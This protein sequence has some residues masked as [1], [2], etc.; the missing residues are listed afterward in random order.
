M[1]VPVDAVLVG[2]GQRGREAFGAFALR[3]PDLLRFVA[4]A[5]PNAERR[6][7]FAR[8][9]GIPADRCFASWTELADRGPLA[10][11]AF[12]TTQ[13]RDHY[14]SALALLA[15]G[16]HLFLEK[17]MATSP[18]ECLAI[19]EAALRHQRMIQIC[20]P[21]RFSPFYQR[22]QELLRSGILGR[23]LS[24]SMAENIG[25]WHYAH[26][27]VR[28]NWSRQ[29]TSGPLML[30]KCC[31]DMDIATWL[32]GAPATSV[33]SHGSRQF[34]R[35]E[36]E[37]DGAA[38]RCLAGCQAAPT[39]AYNASAA[40]LTEQP[41]EDWPYSVV[42]LD[43]HPEV[44]LKALL[45]GPYGRC[46]FRCDN[47][48]VDQQA[49]VATFPNGQ[50]LDFTVR[51]TSY[52]LHR[53]IRIQGTRA[54]LNGHFEKN[55]IQILPH[56]QGIDP[57]PQPLIFHTEPLAGGHGGGDEGAARNFLRCYRE[58]DVTSLRE[59]LDIAV[60][61]HLLAFAAEDAR[62]QGRSVQPLRFLD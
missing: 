51:A 45:E 37:P 21:L 39:C 16:Y 50:L 46:V 42:S 43:P 49:L 57:T 23:I 17:P 14:S 30:T 56:R 31:H 26:S 15:A 18:Q 40:Y 38:D 9:H 54:E 36:N 55:E 32:A 35:R 8:Q 4:V 61:G 22:I 58:N 48:V 28:G 34:F 19:R 62:V 47:D 27:F 24:I 60:A 13:D 11:L 7:H 44:R 59:S 29:S 10:P 41:R 20:H 1:T 2:A 25:Y 33:S 5:E 6:E 12:N 3:N 52:H 53:T